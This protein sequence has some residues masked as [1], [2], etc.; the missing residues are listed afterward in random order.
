MPQFQVCLQF[1]SLFFLAQKC[2]ST[3]LAGPIIFISP[4]QLWRHSSLTLGFSP[5]LSVILFPPLPPPHI[6]AFSMFPSLQ[7]SLHATSLS[8]PLFPLNLHCLSPFSLLSPSSLSAFPLSLS[9]LHP[10]LPPSLLYRPH[11]PHHRAAGLYSEALCALWKIFPG[12]LQPK[13]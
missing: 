5:L 7:P 3:S 11:S 8:I 1:F 12:V 9:S 2:T 10:S 4:L 13:R 6:S